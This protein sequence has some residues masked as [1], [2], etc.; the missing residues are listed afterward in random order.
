VI[1]RQP[2]KIIGASTSQIAGTALGGI[3]KYP[4]IPHATR[5]AVHRDHRF[6][7]GSV[8]PVVLSAFKEY[9]DA[10]HRAFLFT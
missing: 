9:G 6:L 5:K 2:A 3:P 1:D 4:V 8:V 10:D 7:W